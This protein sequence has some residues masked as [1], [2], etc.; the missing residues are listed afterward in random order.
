ML[1]FC[2]TTAEIRSVLD[3]GAEFFRR[4]RISDVQEYR[5][6]QGTV[7]LRARAIDSFNFV[8]RPAVTV[9]PEKRLLLSST[10]DCGEGRLGLCRHAVA[11]LLSLGEE[12]D[13]SP[14]ADP[15]PR[16]TE[17][18]PN[19]ITVRVI[20]EL[21]DRKRPQKAG[22][23][24]PPENNSA[25]AA[26]A[27]EPPE[28]NPADAAKAPEPPENSPADAAGGPSPVEPVFR[29]PGIQ[30]R[31]GYELRTDEPL[32][33]TLNDTDRLFHTNTGII[34]TMGTGKTQLTKSIICQFMRGAEK[35]FGGGDLG[36]LVF[37]YKGDYNETKEDFIKATGARILK[38][39]RLPYNPLAL[40]PPPTSK[41]LLPFHTAGTFVDVLS[42]IYPL[43]PKQQRL[44]LDCIRKAY[45]K[46][47][48]DSNRPETWNRMPPNFAMVHDFYAEETAGR[49]ADSL[50]SAVNTLYD[51]RI[52][53]DSRLSAGSIRDLMTGVVVVDV[54]GYDQ[55][56]QNL[57][58][59][60][61]LELFYAQM[62]TLGSSKTDGRYRQIRQ[63][64]L[65]DEADNFMSKDFPALRRILK[66][67]R[68]FG[69]GMILSTQSLSHFVSGSD[70]YSR[71]ILSWIVHALTDL[72]Q[73]DVEY[74][75]KLPSR[76]GKTAALYSEIKRLEKHQS[77]VKLANDDPVLIRDLPFW[78]LVRGEGTGTA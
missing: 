61:T 17:A 69:V 14:A 60:I 11:L 53:D 29:A 46:C 59:A 64:I 8:A 55:H 38:P 56:I 20:H 66:E 43:G 51:F 45:E 28:N 37:D 78:K 22:A 9:D 33:W 76:A 16:G 54:S 13:L 30:V 67:G 73:K 71:Y 15:D 19:G 34:G 65:V 21:Q 5:T 31:L 36:V 63:L 35:N 6:D 2:N 27:P 50:T 47:G 74:I 58:V 1:H 40:I 26:K 70:N 75:F 10:C 18:A 4:N 42:R 7:V 32:E 12:I 62:L 49:P 44:L 3:S 68:E 39:Y 52:F 24:D 57:V 23:S 48:I 77:V 41:P 72:K 25:D